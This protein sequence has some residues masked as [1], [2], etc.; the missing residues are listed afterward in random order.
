M[1]LL[2]IRLFGSNLDHKRNEQKNFLQN[3]KLA[4]ITPSKRVYSPVLVIV[5]LIIFHGAC[6]FSTFSGFL[7]WKIT[8][9]GSNV[10]TV[11]QVLYLTVV[12][13]GNI[14]IKEVF[15]ILLRVNGVINF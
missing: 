3:L 6:N 5:M 14:S 13:E 1:R 10:S 4:L 8:S 2:N 7:R 11:T 15:T 9:T 12:E